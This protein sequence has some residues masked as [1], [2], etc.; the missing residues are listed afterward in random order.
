MDNQNIIDIIENNSYLLILSFLLK[1]VSEKVNNYTS[2][3][4][5]YIINPNYVKSKELNLNDIY[6]DYYFS[7]K[8]FVYLFDKGIYN[9][10]Y[11]EMLNYYTTST[12]NRILLFDFMDA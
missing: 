11:Q 10:Q 4:G 2:I 5:T 7:K 9:F 1:I 8:N 6:S 3:Q 12:L